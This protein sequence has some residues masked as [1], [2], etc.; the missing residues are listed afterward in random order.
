MKT[1]RFAAC[2]FSFA[3]VCLTALSA[4]DPKAPATAKPYTIIGEYEGQPPALELQQAAAKEVDAA[5]AAHGYA[6]TLKEKEGV[7]VIVVRFSRGKY[8][9]DYNKNIPGSRY[10]W[11]DSPRPPEIF[12]PNNDW[13]RWKGLERSESG[14]RH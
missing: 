5:M 3:G 6:F 11:G 9:I 13:M 2:L 12:F 7:E 8:E 10:A 1:L 14:G 4:T